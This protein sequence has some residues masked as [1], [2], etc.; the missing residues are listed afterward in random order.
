MVGSVMWVKRRFSGVRGC[1]ARLWS[2]FRAGADGGRVAAHSKAGGGRRQQARSRAGERQA[3]RVVSALLEH[4]VLA[5][6][7]ARAPL[8]LVFPAKLASRWLPGLFP[9]MP[10]SPT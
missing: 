7:S 9:E 2:Y 4:G 6:E 1:S 5:S 8:R 3:R 10:A